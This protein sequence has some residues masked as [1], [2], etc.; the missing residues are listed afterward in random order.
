MRALSLGSVLALTSAAVLLAPGPSH[1]RKFIFHEDEVAPPSFA[2]DGPAL[3]A[4]R[5]PAGA[6]VRAPAHLAGGSLAALADGALVLDADS[7]ELVR[8]DARGEPAARLAIA[9]DAAQLVVDRRAAIAYVSDRRGDGVVVVD[10]SAPAPRVRARWRTPA[11]PFGLALSPDGATLLVTTVADRTLIAFD[12]RAGAERWRR[13]LGAEPR[14]VAIS[15]D[16]ALALVT[17]LTSAHVDRI[18]LDRPADAPR[19]AVALGTGRVTTVAARPDAIDAATGGHRHP[20]AA[21]AARFVGNRVAIVPHQVSTPLQET[22]GRE[23]VGSYGGGFEP[24]IHHALTFL[25]A[26]DA[27]VPRTVAAQ[28]AI[29]Q[30]RALAWD[31][32]RDRLAVAGFGSDSLLVLD[33]ASQAGVHH[34]ADAALADRTCGPAGL[35]FADDGALLV[36][37]AVSRRTARVTVA[38]RT[39]AQVSWGPVLTA[40]RLSP[41]EH[42]GADLFRRGNDFRMSSRGAM[43]CSSCHPEGRT[44]GLSWRIEGHTL[45]TPILAGRIADTHPYKWD[46][47][48]ADLTISLTSTMRRLGGGGLRKDEVKALAAFVERA[49]PPRAPTRDPAR[50]ARGRTLYDSPELGCATCHGGARLTD[51]QRHPLASDLAAVDTPSL[52]GLAASAPYY[53][54]GSAATLEALLADRGLVHGMADLGDLTATQLAD[55]VAYLE[56]L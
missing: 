41:L 35:A 47:G 45:Q 1:A 27:E 52:I 16:G 30:P 13:P 4:P 11:E 32:A 12:T 14:G 56:T 5:P 26:G 49:P 55:L 46:G 33:A 51:R 9:P 39:A 38:A 24:P 7:G 10:V 40:T 19:H 18:A 31:P 48:D 54:D 17:Y 6:D 20:R 50:V 36:W 3:G 21:F 25:A 29:H 53:H 22:G 15:P 42:A 37:C 34:V 43:A 44:D 2:L 8:I 28:I 23:N